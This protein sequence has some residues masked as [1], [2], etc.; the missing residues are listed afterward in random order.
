MTSPLQR[1]ERITRAVSDLAP[2]PAALGAVEPPELRDP[3]ETHPFETRNIHPDLPKKV[4][5]L[6]DDGHTEQSVFEAFKFIEKEVKRISG[7]KGKRAT[8]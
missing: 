6:F 1:F 2:A 7:L 3:A 5:S 8:R 4:R